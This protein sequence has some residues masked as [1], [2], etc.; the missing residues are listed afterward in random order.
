MQDWFDMRNSL[1]TAEAIV[2]GAQARTESRGAH[3]RSD[4]P[5]TDPDQTHNLTTYLDGE[6]LS[7]IIAPLVSKYFDLMPLET[8]K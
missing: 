8:A 7:V 4:F 6:G 1:I 3:Q 5:R 2:A